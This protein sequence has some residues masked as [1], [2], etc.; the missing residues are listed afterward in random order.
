M[1]SG[2]IIFYGALDWGLGHA[3]RSVPIIRQL[4]KGNSVI[5]GVTPLTNTIFDEEFPE[6]KKIELP[7]YDIKYSSVFPLWLKLG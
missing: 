7:A 6:L 4:L 3:T 5:L 2:K 1:I